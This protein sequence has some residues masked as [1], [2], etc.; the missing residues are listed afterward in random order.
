[1]RIN[2]LQTWYD[3]IKSFTFNRKVLHPV[4][5]ICFNEF[6]GAECFFG[7]I[8]GDG[9]YEILTYQGPGV[10]GAQNLHNKEH[11]KKL[12]LK[13]VAV[14]AFD[15][16]GNRLWTWGKPHQD[17]TPYLS[18]A[19]ESCLDVAD[20][21]NDGN[22]EVVLADG[23]RIVVI[24]GKTGSEKK[25]CSLM[26]DNF[27]V[28]KALNRPTDNS[29][30]A[31][32]VKNGEMGY[33]GWEYGQPVIGMN[34]ELDIVWGPQNILGGGHYIESVDLNGNGDQF[35]LI[36]YSAVSPKGEILWT[37]DTVDQTNYNAD[38]MHVDYTDIVENGGSSKVL[39][40]AGSD[41]LYVINHE[42][43]IIFQGELQVDKND[44]PNIQGIVF[45]NF[46]PELGIQVACYNA[47]F[48]PIVL[49]DLDGK[50][51]WSRMPIRRWPLGQPQASIGRSFHRN[52]PIV[53]IKGSRD[54]IGFADG[55]WPW[56]IN[57][58]GQIDLLFHPPEN[59]QVEDIQI[60]KSLP[61]R[62]DDAG[63]GFA[64]QSLDIDGDGVDEI[65]IYNRKYLWIYRLEE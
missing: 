30:A 56:A 5:E 15:L 33:N 48:G 51:R 45:G 61:C 4:S 9:K 35:Y 43:D 36:G 6:G 19:Y 12:S 21:D 31:I 18:H 49:F 29:E 65:L 58:D 54:R 38:M 32:V 27:Y 1:M 22:N 40:L 2:K 47:K 17:N 11:I 64:M 60:D 24:D 23:D 16:H 53:K 10:F 59:S 41:K 46:L 44:V 3:S 8:N 57:G 42:G 63:Y 26:N 55:G 34:N 25:T 20:I 7:D 13:T 39:A 50:Q 52:R 62:A 37:V 28:V 14:S